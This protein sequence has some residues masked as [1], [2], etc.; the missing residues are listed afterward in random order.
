MRQGAKAIGIRLPKDVLAQIERLSREEAE[1]RSSMIRKLVLQGYSSFVREKATQKYLAGRVTFSQ[2]AHQAGLTLWEM[3]KHLADRGFR[4]S[5][6][7]E[8]LEGE[9][10][11]LSK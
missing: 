11:L 3:E 4:S 5:Y 7:V 1:D 8:D 10:R 6:S 2:A 9:L